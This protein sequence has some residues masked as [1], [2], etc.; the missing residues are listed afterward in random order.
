SDAGFD[1][2]Y[3]RDPPG[4]DQPVAVVFDIGKAI[5]VEP[6]EE[7][8]VASR[9]TPADARADRNSLF[10]RLAA[11]GY[12]MGNATQPQQQ[13]G[14]RFVRLQYAADNVRTALQDK[15]LPL[16][17]A[18]ERVAANGPAV[19]SVTLDDAMTAYRMEN[20]MHGAVKNGLDRVQQRYIQPIQD[21]LRKSP[22]TM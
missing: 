18:Q 5:P 12:R 10:G 3:Y 22:F 14:G 4:I 8:I 7:G 17:R 11:A 16:L 13:T 20:L 2:F 15:M 21:A 1:G 6:V 9:R 19:S